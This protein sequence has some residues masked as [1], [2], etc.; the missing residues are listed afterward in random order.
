MAKVKVRVL[1]P[2]AFVTFGLGDLRGGE[3]VSL[4][5]DDAEA[6]FKEGYAEPV[7]VKAESTKAKTESA[8]KTVK[9]ENAAVKLKTDT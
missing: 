9:T 4:E 7:K 8:S 3:E 5:T 2:S 1:Y 6:L